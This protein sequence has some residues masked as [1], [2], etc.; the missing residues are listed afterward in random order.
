MPYSNPAKSPATTHH[1]SAIA[2][3]RPAGVRLNPTTI[4]GMTPEMSS[5]VRNMAAL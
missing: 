5:S 3:V 2:C 4:T 1:Q